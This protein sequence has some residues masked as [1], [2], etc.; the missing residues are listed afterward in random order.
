MKT[1]FLVLGFISAL[2]CPEAFAGDSAVPPDALL[3]QWRIQVQPFEVLSGDYS[4]GV[5]RRVR[6][7]WDLGTTVSASLTRNDRNQSEHVRNAIA[8]AHYADGRGFSADVAVDLRHW[9]SLSTPVATFAG[10]QFQIGYGRSRETT[11]ES[12]TYNV[13]SERT[14]NRSVNESFWTGMFVLV[15]ADLRLL[16]RL[17]LAMAMRPLGFYYQWSTYENRQTV[18]AANHQTYPAGTS[19]GSSHT[20][21]IDLHLRPFAFL[22]FRI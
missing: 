6:P 13:P 10:P 20:G 15:G 11:S 1:P 5:Y 12:T 21:W 3:P 9:F 8:N 14:E 16:P 7:R 18:F 17:S 22:S 19:Y 4:T 2:S